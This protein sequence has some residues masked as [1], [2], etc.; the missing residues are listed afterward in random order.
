MTCGWLGGRMGGL[1]GA[2]APGAGTPVCGTPGA[3]TWPRPICG[4]PRE[5][6]GM[7]MTTWGPGEAAAGRGEAA[8]A[9]AAAADS[10]RPAPAGR[11][12]DTTGIARMVAGVTRTLE[13]GVMSLKGTVAGRGVPGATA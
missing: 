9:A 5:A 8:A 6:A 12:P 4:A 10:P 13:L 11:G 3:S 7:P 1:P 2:G